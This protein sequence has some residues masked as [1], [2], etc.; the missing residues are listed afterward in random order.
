MLYPVLSARDM[1]SLG[2]T[3]AFCLQHGDRTSTNLDSLKGT[4]QGTIHTAELKGRRLNTGICRP[5]NEGLTD[6]STYCFIEFSRA[7]LNYVF[8]LITL[9]VQLVETG[10]DD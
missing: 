10:M 2:H 8:K 1:H 7:S 6:I 5:S 4:I 3:L 9:R